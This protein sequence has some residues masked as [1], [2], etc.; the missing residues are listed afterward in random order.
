[1][2]GDL[3][4]T[5]KN[6]RWCLRCRKAFWAWDTGR[7]CCYLCEPPVLARHLEETPPPLGD[8]RP[9]V[10][11]VVEVKVRQ[12]LEKEPEKRQRHAV[13]VINE[14]LV[15]SAVDELLVERARRRYVVLWNV[16]AAAQAWNAG[17]REIATDPERVGA[18]W[19][20]LGVSVLLVLVSVSAVWMLSSR[21]TPTRNSPAPLQQPQSESRARELAD[22]GG[23]GQE[24][25][26]PSR[27]S[28]PARIPSGAA[29][30]NTPSPQ[31]QKEVRVP[32]LT[33]GSGPGKERVETSA[34]PLPSQP[35]ITIPR[36][37]SIP[38]R[39]VRRPDRSDDLKS[40]REESDL[41]PTARTPSSPRPETSRQDAVP[42]DPTAIIDWLL[43]QSSAKDR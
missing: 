30:T 29:G 13:D 25:S 32:D 5:T 31:P 17:A 11:S 24:G 12:A 3:P 20:L 28:V 38:Q 9:E 18:R 7:T 34:L 37:N 42:S 22:R 4:A 36:A 41:A 8:I 16:M 19:M 2:D 35:S 33:P 27:S 21:Q 1:M 43:K 10:P 15:G 40:R 23:S 26:E 14:S 6:E 39:T